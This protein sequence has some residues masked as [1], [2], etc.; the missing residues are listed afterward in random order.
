MDNGKWFGLLLCVPL[1]GLL[2]WYGCRS[3]EKTTS[4]LIADLKSPSDKDRLVAARSRRC[5]TR[6]VP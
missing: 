1:L 6:G 5:S 3:R 4:E 2:G